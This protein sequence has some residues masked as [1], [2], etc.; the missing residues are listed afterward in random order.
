MNKTVLIVDDDKMVRLFLRKLCKSLDLACKEAPN[1]AQALN[2]LSAGTVD[3]V[4]SDLGMP[5]ESGFHLLQNIRSSGRSVPFMIFSGSLNSNEE[6]KKLYEAGANV[7]LHKS[8]DISE[9]KN[10][11][12]NLLKSAE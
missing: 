7:I 2:L 11:I 5:D 4:I 6:E 3:L 12:Q 1:V 9:L 8:A 10:A